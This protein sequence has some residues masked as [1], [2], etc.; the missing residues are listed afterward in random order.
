MALSTSA[1]KPKKKRAAVVLGC[2]QCRR[3]KVKDSHTHPPTPHL[4]NIEH[5]FISLARLSCSLLDCDLNF[6]SFLFM[7]ATREGS[8]LPFCNIICISAVCYELLVLAKHV[9]AMEQLTTLSPSLSIGCLCWRQHHFAML[10]Q[11]MAA[12]L[13][14]SLC[15]RSI[16]LY[17]HRDMCSTASLGWERLG[18]TKLRAIGP[19]AAA[20]KE[21]MEQ[22]NPFGLSTGVGQKQPAFYDKAMLGPDQTSVLHG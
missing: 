20:V 3:R 22:G 4:M 21:T 1:A 19:N 16:H 9:F 18:D 11:H 5:W 8:F 10:S 17:M 15:L 7:C 14:P 13:F 12:M 6:S 2:D